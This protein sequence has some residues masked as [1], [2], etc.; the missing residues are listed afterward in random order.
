MINIYLFDIYRLKLSKSAKFLY[1]F[2]FFITYQKH[3]W[4]IKTKQLQKKNICIAT[5]PI[6]ILVRRFQVYFIFYRFCTHVFAT[7]VNIN[8]LFRRLIL[9]Q[10][11]PIL[12]DSSRCLKKVI[13]RLLLLTLL[14]MKIAS[15]IIFEKSPFIICE[16]VSYY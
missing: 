16:N 1:V 15:S 6:T 2:A 11:Y 7:I 10:P 4:S 9:L 8:I 13:Q 14:G 5:I 12:L 3:K